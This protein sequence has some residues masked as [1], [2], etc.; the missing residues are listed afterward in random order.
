M[1]LVNDERIVK[2]TMHLLHLFL[3]TSHI[4]TISGSGHCSVTGLEYPTEGLSR[5]MLLFC[6]FGQPAWLTSNLYRAFATTE[7]FPLV[8]S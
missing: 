7:D 6:R 5:S 8:R 4:S 2:V 3:G 1:C